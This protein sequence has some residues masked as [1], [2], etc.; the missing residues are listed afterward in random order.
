M[1]EVGFLADAHYLVT[2]PRVMRGDMAVLAGE[3]LV[4]EEDAHQTG[5]R[6]ARRR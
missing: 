3:I 5:S 6:M 1:G 4:D 2:V